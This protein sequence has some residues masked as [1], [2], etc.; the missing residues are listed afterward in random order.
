VVIGAGLG[1]GAALSLAG[2]GGGD[3]GGGSGEPESAL[4]ARVEDTSSKAV[5]GGTYQSFEPN[6]IQGMDPFGA[7]SARA[8]FVSYFVYP[9]MVKTKT[10]F[11]GTRSE[12]KEGD[13]AESWEFSG[14]GLTLTFKLRPGLTWDRRAPTNG[15]AVDANDVVFSSDRFLRLSPNANNFFNSKSEAAP[16]VS[17]QAAD[18]RTVVMKLKFP[19]VPLIATLS[20]ALNIQ[21]MPRESDGGFDPKSDARGAGPWTVSNYQASSIIEF[22]RNPEWYVKGRPFL[23]GW[24]APIVPEYATQLAQFR[25]GNI[26]GGVVRQEDVLAVK[27]DIPQLNIF[28]GDYGIGTPSIFFGFQGPFKDARIRQA[29]SMAI[30]RQLLAET[31]S[32]SAKFQAAGLPSTIRLNNFIGAGWEGYWLEP[33]GKDMGDAAKY[34]KLDLA[35]ARKLLNAAGVSGKLSTKLSYPHNGYG[36]V[37]Q[38]AVQLLHGIIQESGLFDARLNPLDY[39]SDYIP[40]VHFGGSAIGAWDGIAVTPAA[41][42]DD[43]GH[44]LLAQYHSGGNASRQPKGE[45]PKLDQMIDAQIRETDVDKRIQLIKDVQRYMV[46]TMIAIPFH[47]QAAGFTLSWPWVG[48]GGAV[49]GG[50]VPP[51]ESL[52]YLWFDK[53]TYDKVKGA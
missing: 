20:R 11:N 37:Y 40:N 26:W 51:T 1:A 21:I 12:D 46:T 41:Q 50:N 47:Y 36:A 4:L 49:R 39:Q 15:R 23:E 52:P 16:I 34:F 45:D 5:S 2:C 43:A 18:A 48:N 32:D 6:D 17:V 53:A 30:D 27:Q 25:A 22:R 29:L 3:D 7:S 44:Q 10:S 31:Q 35:E 38:Q 13:L 33:D 19:Y 8:Q 9:R 42:G 24:S 28:K 14:D